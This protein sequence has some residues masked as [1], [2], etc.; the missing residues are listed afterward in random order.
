VPKLPIP[1]V[2]VAALLVCGGAAL[3]STDDYEV[4]VVL[5]NANNVFTGSSVMRNGF[6]AGTVDRVE[7]V[8]GRAK[9]TLKLDESFGRLHDG[10]RAHVVWKGA[11]GE[12]WVTL[13]DGPAKNAEIPSG[14]LLTDVAS[15]P[16]EL[17]E[18]LSALDKPTRTKVN[19]LIKRVN[20]TTTGHEDDMQEALI[21][22][23]PAVQ[24][25]GAVLGDLGADGEA[26]KQ[27][28]A[29][30]NRTMAILSARQ[31]TL[32]QVVGNL[33]DMSASV[34]S[35]R[36][37]LGQTLDRLPDV[38]EE[39]QK[40]FDVV[41]GAVDETVPL[42]E[43]LEPATENLATT[44]K[45]LKPVLQDLRPA[46]H[47]LRPA[48][49]SLAGLLAQTPAMMDSGTA[50]M[51]A[52]DQALDD[53][54]PAVKFL[55]P[56]TP[57]FIGWLSNWGSAGGNYDSNGHYARFHILTGTESLL[58]TGT[59]GPGVTQNLTPKPGDPVGQSW[60]DAYGDGLR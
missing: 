2:I 25:L 21:A 29:Q 34:V 60:E 38:L 28:L 16:V 43:D 4:A 41:P 30:S 42:L 51:P 11:L 10:V 55:R 15:E 5:P 6:K 48:L 50:T 58:L 35:E 18:V 54:Q 19:T 59:K 32:A 33:S 39:G 53:T 24:Q 40:T 57:E 27:I 12:R 7:V 52:A 9:L 26:I 45:H 14:A 37:Q 22:A 36:Q 17:S 31:Q 49:G 1:V 13:Q 46:V 8:D 23:G 56:Y 47:D 20:A 44:S 3:I